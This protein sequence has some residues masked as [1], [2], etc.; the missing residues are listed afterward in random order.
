MTPKQV[1]PSEYADFFKTPIRRLQST[2][3]CI[4][5]V[6]EQERSVTKGT[7]TFVSVGSLKFLVTARHVVRSRKLRRHRL[8]LMLS[9]L[10]T[11]GL[12]VQGEQVVPVTLPLELEIV[13]ESKPLDVAFVRAPNRL[14]AMAEARFFDGIVHADA[15]THLRERWRAHHT[16]TTSLPYFVLG[17]PNFGHLRQNSSRVETLSTAAVTAYVT[18]LEPFSWDGHSKRAPQLWL[19]VD[20]REDR[21]I[22]PV[23]SMQKEISR[24]LFHRRKGEPQPLG[25]FS[26]GP[27]AVVGED[28]EFLLGII[29]QG[30][31]LFGTHFRVIASCWDDCFQAFGRWASKQKKRKK[32]NKK[33]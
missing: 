29:K 19:E 2:Y 6:D 4:L 30:K 3:G 7:A 32:K 5:A 22:G 15:A 12:A 17:F 21:L 9:P 28:G 31:P 27:V 11:D 13:W 24:R 26:G 33:T 20:A 18:Q 1:T 23:S 10:G 8:R 25:G 16:D 14:A